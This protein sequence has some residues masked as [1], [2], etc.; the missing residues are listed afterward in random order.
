M[1]KRNLQIKKFSSF[2]EQEKAD[3]KYWRSLSLTAKRKLYEDFFYNYLMLEHG[4]VP[5]LQRV[6]NV[7]KRKK[8]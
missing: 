6:I 2:S 5:R 3:T 7:T 4:T 1:K 8:G